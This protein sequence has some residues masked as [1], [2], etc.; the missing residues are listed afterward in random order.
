MRLSATV[1]SAFRAAKLALL[2]LLMGVAT[3]CS[4]DNRAVFHTSKGDFPFAVEIADTEASRE[5]GLMFRTSLAPDAGML[6]DYHHEQQTSFWMQN[7][8]IPLDMIF[9][10]ADGIVKT[11]HV[12]AQPRDTTSIPSGVPIRFVM[13]IPGGRSEEIGLKV[14]DRFEHPRVGTAQ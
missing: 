6:F 8:L 10:S 3:A 1:S 4:A 5:R 11:I 9:I 7:T 2:L 14:G 13:E 12:N